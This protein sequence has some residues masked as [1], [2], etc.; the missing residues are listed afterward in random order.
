MTAAIARVLPGTAT[1]HVVAPP[2][3]SY[4]HRA[5]V[6]GHLTRR[7]YSVEGPLDA[8]DTRATARALGSLGSPVHRVTARWTVHPVHDRRAS[9][10]RT[11]GCGESGTTVRFAAA[12]SALYSSPTRLTGRG[13]LAT[14]PLSPLLDALRS[15]GARCAGSG[16]STQLPVTISGPIDGGTV[17]VDASESSQFASALLLVLPTL[18]HDSVL[19]LLGPIVSEP[20][21]DATR[22]VMR[23]HGVEVSGTRRRMRIR[24]GQSY[25]G[26]RFLVPGDA[27]SAAYLWVAAAVT[28]G[29]VRVDGIPGRWPQADLAVLDLVRRAGAEVRAHPS[30]VTVRGGTL[31]PFTIDLTNA[32]D[33]YPLAGVLA[34]AT[35]GTSRLRG[36]PHVALKESNRREGTVRLARA[37]GATV[38]T[39]EGGLDIGGLRRPR[40]LAI[41]DLNDHRLVM[42]AA[43]GALAADG[44]STIGDARAVAKSFPGFW[45]TLD[46]IVGGVGR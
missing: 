19:D 30:G 20:Y 9:R 13:R 24:G 4:T 18:A 7:I 37:M 33:L 25:S 41:R 8:D 43:V 36:A 11:I 27:S 2:S 45:K 6:V 12:L 38:R 17:A 16:G 42:S 5:L 35:P 1:G 40:A 14:R 46:S 22:A 10:G 21:I 23:A 44:S 31:R 28:A 34:A 26:S 15:L 3:K 29:T 39:Q 32:P